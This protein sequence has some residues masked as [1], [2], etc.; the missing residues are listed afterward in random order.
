MRFYTAK[1]IFG[2]IAFMMTLCF[3]SYAYG[4][5]AKTVQCDSVQIKVIHKYV[6][7]EIIHV[8][9]D[10]NTR[11]GHFINLDRTVYVQVNAS[12]LSLK[13]DDYEIILNLQTGCVANLIRPL[14]RI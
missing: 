11:I 13:M 12:T 14:N 10:K 3:F 5:E 4:D 8:K 9:I 6:P 2:I 1:G 7:S